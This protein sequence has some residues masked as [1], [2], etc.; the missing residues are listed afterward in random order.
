M[1]ADGALFDY[2]GSERK[3]T[4]HGTPYAYD[5]RVPLLAWGIGVKPGLAQDSPD[6]QRIAPTVAALL[7]VTA[8]AQ[9]TLP[10]I[11]EAL[12]ARH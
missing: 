2:R 12:S 4:S 11:H 7:G 3:G 9:S 1:L 6:T 5:D 8:T 10:P